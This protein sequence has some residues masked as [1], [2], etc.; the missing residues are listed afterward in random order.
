[1]FDEASGLPYYYHTK[2]GDT[3]WE[4]PTEA[5]VIPLGILQNTALARRLSMTNR[6]SL[7]MDG[8]T[9]SKSSG[10]ERAPYRRSRSYVNEREGAANGRTNGSPLQS[11]RSQS[12]TRSSPG[13]TQNT[14]PSPTSPSRNGGS[15]KRQTRKSSDHAQQSSGSHSGPLAFDR[16]HP[17]TPIP[18]SPYNSDAS[19]PP[20]V[21]DRNS[22]A[23]TPV[24]GRR[25][26]SPK[27]DSPPK[28]KMDD[29]TLSRS[30]SKSSSYMEYRSAQPQS[31]T[32]ALEMIVSNSNP[33]TPQ[34]ALPPKGSELLHGP[35]SDAGHAVRSD[36]GLRT[37]SDVG[38][39][40][41]PQ[42]SPPKMKINTDPRLLSGVSLGDSLHTP[43]T[44]L[45]FKFKIG[46]DKDKS[47]PS[48]PSRP[49]PP[50]APQPR[51]SVSSPIGIQLRGKEISSPVLNPGASGGCSFRFRA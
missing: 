50:I 5:F 24:S 36:H 41:R 13:R 35:R 33:S 23:S 16:G 51:R 31:L 3:V 47:V 15:G 48:T 18:G 34:D 26:D 10:A 28:G 44:P 7:L 20:S 14:P 43:E 32:A 45:R 29:P 1:M 12:S 49:T 22:P 2:T 39:G 38:H 6:A 8:K 25:K 11:R 4:R 19:A 46:K 37:R 21:R 42:D 17:L 40:M 30:R 27:K 9:G